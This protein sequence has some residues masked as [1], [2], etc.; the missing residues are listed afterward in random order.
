MS[1]DQQPSLEIPTPIQAKAKRI[2]RYYNLHDHAEAEAYSTAG[3]IS[4]VW[5]K[6]LDMVAEEAQTR[7]HALEDSLANDKP[8]TLVDV[9]I[10]AAWAR[11]LA[12]NIDTDPS[13]PQSERDVT[14][15]YRAVDTIVHYLEAHTGKS[16]DTLGLKAWWMAKPTTEAVQE[17]T[18]E[19]PA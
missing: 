1:E 10:L 17:E 12:S 2:G 8:A 18:D 3:K 6:T 11:N 4:S 14:W 5:E 16:L 7:A 19:P 15:L 13:R 9:L